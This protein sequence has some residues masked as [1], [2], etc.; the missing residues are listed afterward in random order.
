MLDAFDE[1]DAQQHPDIISLIQQ[2]CDSGMKVYVTTRHHLLEYLKA[3][4]QWATIMKI[5]A[6]NDDVRT[7]LTWQLSKKKKRISDDL[8]A[9]IIRT[10]SSKAH[11]MYVFL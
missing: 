3:E 11:G 7:Y 8:K 2:F 9:K 10:I 1:C 4:F 5:S 6:K